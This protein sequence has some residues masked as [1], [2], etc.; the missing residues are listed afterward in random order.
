MNIVF[1][2]SKEIGLYCLE[3]LDGYCS[4]NTNVKLVGVLTNKRGQEVHDYCVKRSIPLINSLEEFLRLD[5]L[6]L[7]I[8]VQY[9]E[10]L[11]KEH[12]DKSE[13]TV[14]LHMAP[15]PE[16]RGCN[17]FTYAILDDKDYFGTT[18]HVIDEGIDSGDILFEDR[19]AL[20]PELWVHELYDL[21]LEKS[22]LLFESSLPHLISGNFTK[23]PQSTL[24]SSR[25]SKIGY[26]KDIEEL[27]FIND[28]NDKADL[29]RRIRA[30]SMPGFSP[31]YL[32]IGGKKIN[33]IMEDAHS[34]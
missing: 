4:R 21:T 20:P 23:T 15:L 11:K 19:F 30:T 31:P 27:K 7:T 14:N 24:I 8:S 5:N 16:Y 13:L 18:I 34:D 32:L 22:R 29:E 2:G 3:A 9:H 33:L 25:G 26:R 17:Q 1:M 28:F 12:I 6:A 10:I